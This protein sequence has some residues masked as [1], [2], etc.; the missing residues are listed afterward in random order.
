MTSAPPPVRSAVAL[1][2]HRNMNPTV[3]CACEG[4]RLCTP[5]EKL[6]PGD[7]SWS[8]GGDASTGGSCK[9]TLLAEKF[10][11]TETV[12]NLLLADSYQNSQM[13]PSSC[14]KMTS[15]LPLILHYGELYN[16]YKL[17]HKVTTTEIKCTVNIMYLNQPP[18][19]ALVCGKTVFHK[20]SCEKAWEPLL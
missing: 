15:R 1:D 5:Y 17:Y 9:Y 7:L 18:H 20:S 10:D 8:W 2:S 3:N 12:I 14:R 13:G 6:M 16:Y 19:P 4:S 11:C